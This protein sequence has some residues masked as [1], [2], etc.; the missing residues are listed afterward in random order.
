[1]KNYIQELSKIVDSM[2][3]SKKEKDDYLKLFKKNSGYT[4]KMYEFYTM[5][6]KALNSKDKKMW[7]DLCLEEYKFLE[8]IS[9]ND[10]I[11]KIHGKLK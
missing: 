7:H 8:S 9:Q 5:K 4:E 11:K 3:L 6:Q 1:M 10:E 2:N